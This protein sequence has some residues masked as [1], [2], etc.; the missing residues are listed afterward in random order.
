MLGD[1]KDPSQYIGEHMM[2]SRHL[3]NAVVLLEAKLV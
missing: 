1:L 2:Y 3:R